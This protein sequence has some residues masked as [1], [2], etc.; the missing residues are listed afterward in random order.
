MENF[1][2]AN[3]SE[4]EAEKRFSGFDPSIKGPGKPSKDLKMVETSSYQS[5]SKPSSRWHNSVKDLHRST[6]NHPVNDWKK[7]NSH[8]RNKKNSTAAHKDINLSKNIVNEVLF[9]ENCK[10]IKF[11]CDQENKKISDQTDCESPLIKEIRVS[12]EPINHDKP[13]ENS[14]FAENLKNNYF[15]NFIEAEDNLAKPTSDCRETGEE[16]KGEKLLE[17]T[18]DNQP[19]EIK[20]RV[21]SIMIKIIEIFDLK[22]NYKKATDPNGMPNEREKKLLEISSKIQELLEEKDRIS[23]PKISNNDHSTKEPKKAQSL[24]A[25]LTGNKE[26]ANDKLVMAEL[27]TSTKLS[28]ISYKDQKDILVQLAGLR[29]RDF[30]GLTYNAGR[31]SISFLV[32]D[33]ALSKYL[34]SPPHLNVMKINPWSPKDVHESI[35]IFLTVC[36]KVV[37]YPPA[38]KAFKKAASAYIKAIQD[39][40]TVCIMSTAVHK[41]IPNVNKKD[42]SA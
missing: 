26:P 40:D 35:N 21:D 13:H 27:K 12:N 14:D 24:L 5:S 41:D 7:Y 32:S 19:N 4:G 3:S 8:R 15:K 1:S 36:V 23:N 28:N 30:A 38:N 20:N 31:D 25:R 11:S 33:K 42:G 37:Q 17:K 10:K 18:V 2:H 34:S 29:P 39:N 9:F 6:I 22:I 16:L